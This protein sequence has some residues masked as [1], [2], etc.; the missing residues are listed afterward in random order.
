M[1]INKIKITSEFC[2]STFNDYLACGRD[3]RGKTVPFS[4]Q[5]QEM[6]LCG[7]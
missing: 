6:G 7:F 3:I 2:Y 5:A 4:F 1:L